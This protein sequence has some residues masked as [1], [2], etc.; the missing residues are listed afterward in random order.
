MT[1]A[2]PGTIDHGAATPAWRQ[3]AAI[4]A[5]RIDGGTYPPGRVLPSEKQLEQEFGLARGTIRKAI[6][7][8]RSED[9]VVTVHG[10]GTYVSEQQDG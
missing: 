4:L 1:T 2:N 7:W 5:A 6:A 10:R 8:L 3:L 9:L